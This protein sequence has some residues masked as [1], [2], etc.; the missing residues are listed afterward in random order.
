MPT[1]WWAAVPS[2]SRRFFAY[3]GVTSETAAVNPTVLTAF[4]PI[5]RIRILPSAV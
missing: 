1:T 2:K 3:C 4:E 5:R